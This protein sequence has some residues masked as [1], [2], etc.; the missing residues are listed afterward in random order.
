MI[1]PEGVWVLQPGEQ[2]VSGR[3]WNNLTVPE[4]VLS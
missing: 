4:K 1:Q 2:K 3:P